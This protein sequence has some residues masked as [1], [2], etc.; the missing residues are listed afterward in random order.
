MT[1]PD[2][3]SP[4]LPAEPTQ[5]QQLA[6][7]IRNLTNAVDNLAAEVQLGALAPANREP[8]LLDAQLALVQRGA[9]Q[10]RDTAPEVKDW[11]DVPA[12]AEVRLVPP[13]LLP[14]VEAEMA[15][16]DPRRPVYVS[17]AR[18]AHGRSRE[19]GWDLI[20]P[21]GLEWSGGE[22]QLEA[23]NLTPADFPDPNIEKVTPS[24]QAIVDFWDQ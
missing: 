20:E 7:A 19:W 6:M 2:F 10:I 22:T 14:A 24:L 15:Y 18:R 8:D 17:I 9:V 21:S 12:G 23:L 13:R 4:I 3:T 16:I 5:I 1:Q 11:P